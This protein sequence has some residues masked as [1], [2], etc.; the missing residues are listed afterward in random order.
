MRLARS[1]ENKERGESRK[2]FGKLTLVVLICVAIL[3]VAE[4]W[5]NH[6]QITYGEKWQEIENL[7][8][9]LV[10]ENQILE[11]Q[12]SSFASLSNMASRSAELG[13]ISPKDIKYMH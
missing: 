7:Q 4:I 3:V 10:T 6:N 1:F 11:N 2:G 8:R 13:F 12:I 9:V 5:V